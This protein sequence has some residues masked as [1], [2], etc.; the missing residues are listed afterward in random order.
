MIRGRTLSIRG[1]MSCFE[2]TLQYQDYA[3]LWA[4]VHDNIGRRIN[5]DKWDNVEKAYWMEE[6][7]ADR[8]NN[9]EGSENVADVN[10]QVAYSSNARFVR[11]GKGGKK[12]RS[13]LNDQTLSAQPGNISMNTLDV[14]FDMDGL[15]LKL[16]R[17]DFPHGIIEDDIA[18]TFHYDFVLLR[19]KSVEVLTTAN[20]NGDISFNLSLFRIGLFDLGDTGRLIRQRYYHALPNGD[21]QKQK[22]LKQSCPFVVLTEGYMP[23]DVSDLGQSGRD[24]P[25]FVVSIDTCPAV[26]T[27]GFG[28]LSGAGLPSDTQ[29]TIAKV[30]VNYLSFNALVRPFQEIAAFFSCEWPNS[31]KNC[32]KLTKVDEVESRINEKL[33]GRK[34]DLIHDFFQGFQLKVVAHYPRVFFLADE[35]D[36]H[37]RALVLKG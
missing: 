31:V 25:E 13:S 32:P 35:S 27:T 26:S 5:T 34:N 15:A 24:G 3:L 17:N 37:S 4:V 28:P 6:K 23:A 18:T 8:Q 30:V 33:K 1:K 36:L 19:V 11:Y 9:I 16:R 2:V 12:A 10:T 29:V 20:A 22:P 7:S 14:R 21:K